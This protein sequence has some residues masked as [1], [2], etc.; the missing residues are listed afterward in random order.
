M[1]SR[2]VRASRGFSLIE[3][4][5]VLGIVGLV[6]GGI[7]AASSALNRKWR[8]EQLLEG[9][10]VVYQ[11]AITMHAGQDLS[12]TASSNPAL[13]AMMAPSSWVQNGVAYAPGCSGAS[14]EL[15]IRVE[16]DHVIIGLVFSATTSSSDISFCVEAANK[17]YNA[18][19]KQLALADAG[20]TADGYMN[21]GGWDGIVV[22]PGIFD[23]T[24][25]IGAIQNGCSWYGPP[26]GTT[27]YLKR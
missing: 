22:G 2:S 23:G 26:I 24:Q 14:C 17:I 20:S 15:Y 16:Q 13:T 11:N 1:K 8:I 21:F 19:E 25:R 27:I 5:I 7:W 10:S 9:L 4:A 6:I 3:A 12:L 18:F